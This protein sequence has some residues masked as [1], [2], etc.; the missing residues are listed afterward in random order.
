[1]FLTYALQ[2]GTQCTQ[3]VHES[4]DASSAAWLAFL[5]NMCNVGA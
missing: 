1:M 2:E 4:E 3:E 5:E